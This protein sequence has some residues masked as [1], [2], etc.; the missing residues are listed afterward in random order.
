MFFNDFQCFSMIFVE[1]FSNILVD[2]SCTADDI[3]NAV[4]KRRQ[5]REISGDLTKPKLKPA[6]DPPKRTENLTMKNGEKVQINPNIAN[7]FKERRRSSFRLKENEKPVEKPVPTAAVEKRTGPKPVSSRPVSM[8]VTGQ[9]YRSYT[10]P[11][12][13]V[14]YRTSHFCITNFGIW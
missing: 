11:I 9:T 1:I 2:L 10:I 5:S 3:R 14:F 8:G 4:E 7:R 6:K 13:A 12:D